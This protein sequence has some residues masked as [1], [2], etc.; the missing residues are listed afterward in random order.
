MYTLY[1]HVV[2]PMCV[3]HGVRDDLL[4]T[5]VGRVVDIVY[6]CSSVTREQSV[7]GPAVIIWHNLQS[8][9]VDAACML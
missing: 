7:S 2:P 5:R 8:Y 1:I 3:C 4:P 6:Y 9:V